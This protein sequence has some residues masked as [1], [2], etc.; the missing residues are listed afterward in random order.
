[1]PVSHVN[2]QYQDRTP[3]IDIH[4]GLPTIPYGRNF[5]LNLWQRTGS[6]NGIIPNVSLPITASGNSISNATQLIEDWNDVD[7]VPGG[8]GVQISP[9]LS[10][11]PGNDIWVFNGSG[12]NLNVY[13]PTAQSQIDALGAGNPFVLA[14]GKMRCFMCW[15]LTQFRTYGN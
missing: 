14:P 5:L 10:L 11:A 4:N 9:T 2:T 12:N 1:M 6:G 15:A 7:T 8:S 3:F 13:P